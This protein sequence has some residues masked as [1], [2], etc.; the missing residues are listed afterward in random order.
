VVDEQLSGPFERKYAAGCV[1]LR[2]P[3]RGRVARIEGLDE[4]QRLV[5]ALV[6]E[7][8]LPKVGAAKAS[9][10]EGDGY[11]ILRHPDTEVV[12]AAL[13]TIVETVKVRYE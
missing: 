13:R 3:G 11:A 7:A 9:G 6:V 2:G 4:A 1:Y 8:N 10:Y 5:G 12:A